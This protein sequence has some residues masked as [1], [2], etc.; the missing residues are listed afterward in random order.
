LFS[1]SSEAEEEVLSMIVPLLLPQ[2]SQ[3]IKEKEVLAPTPSTKSSSQNAQFHHP[4]EEDDDVSYLEPYMLQGYSSPPN[5][6]YH[7]SI[8]HNF[9]QLV[10][11]PEECDKELLLWYESMC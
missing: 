1:S 11:T 2:S 5:L 6:Q 7:K 4:F 3:E 10:Q 8:P 9:H